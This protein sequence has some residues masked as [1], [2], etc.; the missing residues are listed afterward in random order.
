M[1]VLTVKLILPSSSVQAG[2]PQA[3]S[4]G[5]PSWRRFGSGSVSGGIAEGGWVAAAHQRAVRESAGRG[6]GL[7]R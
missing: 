7:P 4:R 6:N 3:I 2:E 1:P 5:I